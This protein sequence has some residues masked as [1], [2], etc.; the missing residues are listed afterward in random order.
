MKKK[1]RHQATSSGRPKSKKMPMKRIAFA[2]IAQRYLE[3]VSLRKQVSEAT[4]GPNA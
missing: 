3:L 1:R 2:N 4:S